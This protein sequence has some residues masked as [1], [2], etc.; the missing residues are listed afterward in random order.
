MQAA[1]EERKR[2]AGVQE[3]KI[4]H[5]TSYILLN[6]E[7]CECYLHYKVLKNHET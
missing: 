5:Q 1:Q 7:L 6:F 3:W 4:F 2:V